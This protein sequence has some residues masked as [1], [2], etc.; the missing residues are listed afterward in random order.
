MEVPGGDRR[1]ARTPLR[2]GRGTVQNNPSSSSPGRTGRAQW[3]FIWRTSWRQQ[4]S[5]QGQTVVLLVAHEK[6]RW[7]FV[8]TIW[9]LRPK[10][11]PGDLCTSIT[12]VRLPRGSPSPS[13]DPFQRTREEV[14]LL[15]GMDCLTKWP[16]VYATSNQEPSAV[17]AAVL[18]ISFHR[19][20]IPREL[21]SDQGRNFE[22][23]ILQ[24]VLRRPGVCK[25]GYTPLRPQ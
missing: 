12:P 23:R 10:P 6:R 17:A 13:R 16:D 20:V 2:V 14:Y 9:H 4:N 1:C 22:P 3:R 8:P 18:I 7:E 21:Q 25:K 11:E 24:E 5:G 15:T 19:F